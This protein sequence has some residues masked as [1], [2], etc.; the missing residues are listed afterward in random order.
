MLASYKKFWLSAFDF[1]GTV[2]DKTFWNNLL[3]TFGVFLVMAFMIIFIILVLPVSHFSH[4]V[5][6]GFFWIV[7]GF[8]LVS[9]LPLTSSFIR[10]LNAVK[11]SHWYILPFFLAWGIIFPIDIITGHHSQI[12]V[13]VSLILTVFYFFVVSDNAEEN[14]DSAEKN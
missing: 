8:V 7:G 11:K 2:D 4:I 1:K 5:L 3:F 9:L 6:Y 13:G 10:R 12:A 14:E